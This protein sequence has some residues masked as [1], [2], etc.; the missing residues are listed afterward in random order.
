M[1]NHL[2]NHPAQLAIQLD[3]VIA[4]DTRNH[5]GAFTEV[6]LIFLAPL[7]PF[8]I[9]IRGALQVTNPSPLI[10][11]DHDGPDEGDEE[12]H[13]GDVEGEQEAVRVHEGEP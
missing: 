3:R 2:V 5:V 6:S 12:H 7:N 10:P 11:R 9:G 8:M 1:T 4:V 13:R